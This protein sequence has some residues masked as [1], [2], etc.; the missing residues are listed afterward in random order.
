MFL[1]FNFSGIMYL[2]NVGFKNLYLLPMIRR[3]ICAC[4]AVSKFSMKSNRFTGVG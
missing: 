2:F 4:S 1:N 3:T